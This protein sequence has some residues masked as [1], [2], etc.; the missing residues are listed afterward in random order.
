MLARDQNLLLQPEVNPAVGL[1]HLN[2]CVQLAGAW[3]KLGG[4]ATVIHDGLPGR[5][6]HK[7]D[8]MAVDLLPMSSVDRVVGRCKPGWLFVDGSENRLAVECLSLIHI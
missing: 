8:A 5:V 1:R 6:I 4:N 7:L 3:Q 2:R